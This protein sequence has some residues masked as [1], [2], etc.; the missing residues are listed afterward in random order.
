MATEK[1]ADL[2]RDQH[3][4]M[5]RELGAHAIAVD[6]VK[7]KKEADFAVIAFFEKKP[8]DIPATLPVKMGKKVIDVPLIAQIAEK[9]RPE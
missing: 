2:A 4:S 8:K 6:K 9:F 5:L 1:Q 3:S 7:S